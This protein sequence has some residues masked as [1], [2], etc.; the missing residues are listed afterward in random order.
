MARGPDAVANWP[1]SPIAKGRNPLSVLLKT[2][3]G[4]GSAAAV[5]VIEASDVVLA[6]IGA[7]LHLDDFQ[8]NLAGIFQAVPRADGNEGGL[9][10]GDQESLVSPRHARRAA[11]DDPVLRAMMVHLQ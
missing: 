7:G 6:E 2:R 4:R 3:R 1:G 10:L 5:G 11:H 9:V 8:G